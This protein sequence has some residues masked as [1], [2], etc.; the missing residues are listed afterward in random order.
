MRIL[1]ILFAGIAGA[2]LVIWT[3][4]TFI[5]K[6]HEVRVS[7]DLASLVY[8]VDDGATFTNA[9]SCVEYCL[10]RRGWNLRNTV[11]ISAGAS[12]A[13]NDVQYLAD[14]MCYHHIYPTTLELQVERGKKVEEYSPGRFLEEFS[15]QR[16][17]KAHDAS[18][19][20]PEAVPG[21]GPSSRTAPGDRGD[22]RS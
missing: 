22:K 12:V 17:K 21:V 19:A 3:F 11:R 13:T 4:V 14:L 5:V 18:E 1:K 2:A 7:R 6:D 15:R 10:G 16:N 8:S 9:E 20:P